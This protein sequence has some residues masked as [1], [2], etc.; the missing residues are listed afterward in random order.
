MV[1]LI[2]SFC[3]ARLVACERAQGSQ[4]RGVDRLDVDDAV[5]WL[6]HDDPKKALLISNVMVVFAN[7]AIW[8]GRKTE[9]ASETIQPQKQNPLFGGRVRRRGAYGEPRSTAVSHSGVR[10]G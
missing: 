9:I 6:C 1:D 2:V 8:C 4:L 10:T 7:H 3:Q 5:S